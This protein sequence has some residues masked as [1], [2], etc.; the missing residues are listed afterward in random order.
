MPA[1]ATM[2]SANPLDAQAPLLAVQDL[3]KRYAGQDVVRQLSFSI[4][5]GECYGIIGP[6]GAGKTTTIRL[7]LG[8]DTRVRKDSV[9][10]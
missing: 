9:M 4:R 10:T 7:C 2:P 5:P 3:H 8:L 6:N 1:N